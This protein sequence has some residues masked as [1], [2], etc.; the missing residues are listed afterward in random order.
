M[1]RITDTLQNYINEAV[2]DARFAVP[3]KQYTL[4]IPE[5][6][7]HGVYACNVALVLSKE[8]GSSPREIAE[9]I[10]TALTDKNHSE[11][12]KL[13]IAGP[14]FIN[15]F[16]TNNA[17]REEIN[18]IESLTQFETK[19]S[20]KKVL[21]EHSSPNLFKPFH[22]GHL[23]NN[24]VGESIV[25]MMKMTGATVTTMSF[26]S[27]ISLGI[28]KAIYIIKQD[29]G[30]PFCKSKGDEII[31]YLGESYVRGVA[32][33]D[34]HTESQSEIKSIAEKLYSGTPSV[35]LEI[36][37]YAKKIN[38]DYF[39]NTVSHIG[40][41]LD[42]LIYES[43]AGVAGEKIVKENTPKVFTESEGAIVYIPEEERKDINT[44]VFINSQGHPTY[45]AKDLGLIELKFNKYNPDYSFFVTDTE[46]ASHFRVVLASVEKINIE[47]SQK[48][49]HITHGRMTFKGA[50]M[51]SRLGGVPLFTEILNAV[52]DEVR[53]KE[54]DKTKDFSEDEKKELYKNVSLSAL[55]YAILRSK[56]GSN[57]NFDPDDN[58]YIVTIPSI[59]PLVSTF[60]STRNDAIEEMM[61][62]LDG[63]LDFLSMVE[64]E[65]VCNRLEYLS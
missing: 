45:E 58:D 26:P 53:S 30:I 60:A 31:T 56:L 19:F 8:A 7:E 23:M 52:E 32:Y 6:R 13:E 49:V 12:A 16:L 22:I 21:V 10:V 43:E 61:I 42:E 63:V 34:E 38:I 36:F 37:E 24:I 3:E 46:Q 50:K 4:S 9:K 11:I 65:D 44:A 20:G 1:K 39:I 27:D 29:G 2:L 41:H 35:E 15:I 17:V 64:L 48:S 18:R 5:R 51:S 54:G 40:T 62:A 25:R 28:A 57:I 47:H 14:G 33:Y 59:F 55:R